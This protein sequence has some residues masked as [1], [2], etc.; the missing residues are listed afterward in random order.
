ME[1]TKNDRDN[2]ERLVGRIALQS[3]RIDD[4]LARIT[5]IEDRI[6]AYMRDPE[7]ARTKIVWLDNNKDEPDIMA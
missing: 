6:E 3:Q 5:S 7:P 4:I 1:F 2:L